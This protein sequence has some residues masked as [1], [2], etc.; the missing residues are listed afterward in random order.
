[1]L[2]ETGP[3]I[4]ISHALTVTVPGEQV[5]CAPGVPALLVV[6]D[7]VVDSVRVAANDSVT[8]F[9]FSFADTTRFRVF[10]LRPEDDKPFR[11]V[12][13]VV[14]PGGGLEEDHRLAAIAATKK[15]GRVRV[16]AV[17][18]GHGGDDSGARGPNGVLEKSV[19]LGVAR[20]LVSTLNGIPGIKAV[21]T[22][23]GDY[24]IPL[25]ERYRAA[26]RMKADLFISI[27]CNASR[28]REATGTEVYFLSLTGATDE[29]SRALADAENAADLIGGTP[30]EAGDDLRSILFDLRQNETVR[31]SSEVAEYIVDA[32]GEE[33]RLHTRGVR[34]A[35]FVVLKAPE[36]PSV[37]V[38]TAFLTNPREAAMLKDNQFQTKLAEK[39]AEGVQK[40]MSAIA[41]ANN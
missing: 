13:D 15:Q 7:S 32:L 39:L 36:I 20:A 18:A 34:Q 19:N 25:R 4:W 12:V 26:E 21:L 23:D 38:E 33:N 1:M 11:I 31:K 22:R 35:G 27:H 28:N 10:I 8:R 3:G 29:A 14:R 2:C 17:D 24:F 30:P 6:R 37:L 9:E 5:I 16:V 40:Y 41:R